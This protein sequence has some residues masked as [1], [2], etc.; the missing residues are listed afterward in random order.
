MSKN[1]TKPSKLEK[2]KITNQTVNLLSIFPQISN[3]LI[4]SKNRKIAINNVLEILGE[5]TQTD[6]VYY[7]KCFEQDNETYISYEAEWCKEGISAQIN[8]PE[9]SGIPWS[10]FPDIFERLLSEDV[11]YGHI[12]NLPESNF[13]EVMSAQDIKSFLFAKV[14]IENN[15]MGFVGFDSCIIKREW[16]N[17]ESNILKYLANIIAN[18]FLAD[19]ASDKA[20]K[21]F[22]KLHKSNVLLNRIRTIQSSFLENTFEYHLYFNKMLDAILEYSGAEI[23]FIGEVLYDESGQPFL[24]SHAISNIS[25]NK[26]TNELYERNK[27]TGLEFKNLKTL[28]GRTLEFDE[29]VISNSPNTDS[30]KGGLPSGHPTLHNFLGCPVKYADK[31]IGMLGLANFKNKITEETVRELDLA[32]DTYGNLIHILR[33][34]KEKK[35]T[36]EIIENQRKAF[37]E[38]FETSLAGYWDWNPIENTEYLSP[39]FKKT[40]GYENHELENTPESWMSLANPQD[41]QKMFADY[42]AHAK[43]GG[44]FPFQSEMRFTHKDGSLRTILCCGKILEWTPKGE[45]QRVIGCHVDLTELRNAEQTLIVREEFLRQISENINLVFFVLS[46]DRNKLLFVNEKIEDL[47]GIKVNEVNDNPSNLLKFIPDSDLTILEKAA[48]KYNLIETGNFIAEHR[49]Q[50]PLT[51]EIKH[52]RTHLSPV[53]FE[54]KIQRIVGFIEDISTSVSSEMK[55]QENLKKEKDLNKLKSYFISMV[56]HQF[57]TPLTIIQSNIELIELKADNYLDF[58]NSTIKHT[59]RIKT[60]INWLTELLSDILLIEKTKNQEREISKSKISIKDFLLSIAADFDLS[61]PKNNIKK[62]FEIKSDVYVKVNESILRHA[63]INILSNA[64]KYGSPSKSPELHINQNDENVQIKII[65]FGI[66]IPE[67]EISNIFT[68]FNRASNVGNIQ[69]TGLGMSIAK[70][71]IEQNNGHITINS[72][73]G[74]GTVVVI[75]LPVFVK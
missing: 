33:L 9:L 70:D 71:F 42:S 20:D 3:T 31:T 37:E 44:E 26:E 36:Q 68:A 30:R 6:R 56:S 5:A 49:I 43:S 52:V 2:I 51:H 32:I 28:F 46:S 73:E 75:E 14:Y 64:Y 7:F 60:E 4:T 8:T 10:Y 47:Y 65:D 25:W 48:I 58:K 27:K 23:G 11:I 62:V 74:L 72:K 41:L 15:F 59:E 12:E 1:Q 40:F 67:A 57:R 54:G 39:K 55:L 38:I 66:G 61:N 17:E 22:S 35:E 45:P 19:E 63:F 53:L 18:K 34:E 13:K 24:R 16:S 50:N 69:G 29:I 21:L